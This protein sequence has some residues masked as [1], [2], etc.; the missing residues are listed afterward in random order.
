MKTLLL[1]FVLAACMLNCTTKTPASP[2]DPKAAA[3]PLVDSTV[4]KH[5]DLSY[6]E[7]SLMFNGMRI[8]RV[9][10]FHG[11]EV[12][13][14]AADLE[15]MG[16]FKTEDGIYYLEKIK[17]ITTAVHDIITDEEGEKTGV[18]VSVSN[19]DSCLLLMEPKPYL[20]SGKIKMSIDTQTD[21][22][23]RDEMD[24]ELGEI[25][26][27][28]YTTE[29]IPAPDEENQNHIYSVMLND[30]GLNRFHTTKLVQTEFWDDQFATLCFAGDIDGDGML[31]LILDTSNHYNM[32][33]I[34]L[35][36]S[37]QAEQGYLVK[38]VGWHVITGC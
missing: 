24:L 16:L 3:E 23:P 37:S 30:G 20:I 29:E 12:I 8:L 35:Y 9:G 26:Y 1:A 17:V 25:N 27:T 18:L 31:D 32:S 38:P 2:R 11:D 28:L 7:D 21:C 33:R 19:K 10:E 15:W 36:L 13:A 14:N 4:K 6:P 5:V 22:I 34:T